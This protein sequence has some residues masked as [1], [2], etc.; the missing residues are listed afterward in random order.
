MAFN[1]KSQGTLKGEEQQSE[2]K[3]KA[4]VPD[5]DVVQIQIYQ[6]EISY[7]HD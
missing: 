2:Q 4:S 5:S 7:H 1:K 6:E 3:K